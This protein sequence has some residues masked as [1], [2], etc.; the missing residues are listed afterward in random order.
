MSNRSSVEQLVPGDERSLRL[1]LVDLQLVDRKAAFVGQF[2]TGSGRVAIAQAATAGDCTGGH[3]QRGEFR[4]QRLHR[5]QRD[6]RQ[7]EL[8]VGRAVVGTNRS[9]GF[10][11]AAAGNL[12]LEVDTHRRTDPGF[13]TRDMRSDRLE[14]DRQRRPATAILEG[15]RKAI[16]FG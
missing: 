13:E 14:A 15:E 12:G 1:D 4:H 5:C 2:G 6:R 11:V 3:H 16:D 8:Q 10:D 7:L 9:L